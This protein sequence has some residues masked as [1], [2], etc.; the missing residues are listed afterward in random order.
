MFL[1]G[2]QQGYIVNPELSVPKCVLLKYF[3]KFTLQLMD[4]EREGLL[5]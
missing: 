3:K 4:D 5:R 1:A 2:R